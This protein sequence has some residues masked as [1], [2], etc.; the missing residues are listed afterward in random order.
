MSWEFKEPAHGRFFQE[1]MKWNPQW[2]ARMAD[3]AQ[4][5]IHHAEGDVLTHVEQVCLELTKLGEFQELTTEEQQILAW[6]ALLHDVAKPD[7]T[8]EEPSGRI[9][10][11][12]HAR[13]GAQTARRILWELDCPFLIREQICGLVHNHMKVFWA[14]ENEEPE[15]TVRAMSLRCS[16]RHLSILAEADARGRQCEDLNDLLHRV[17]LFR[18]LA[19]E[20]NCYEKP[21][22]FASEVGRYRYLQG[23]WHNPELP[24][25]EEFRCHAILLSGLPAS[26]KDTWVKEQ[27]RGWPVVSLDRWRERLGISPSG[28]QG[29]V[30]EA[31]REEAREY[32][33]EGRDFIWNA[34]NV[35]PLIR[36]KCLSLIE[37]YGA[38]AS[39]VYLEQPLRELARRNEKRVQQ[40]PWVAIDKMLQRWDIPQPAEAPALKYLI[41]GV[42][43]PW[44]LTSLDSGEGA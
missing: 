41:E 35:S 14:L 38:R 39:I 22:G 32:L 26:G 28:T 20:Y 43:V 36:R 19:Q 21:A 24:P 15:R 30:V 40:V 6:A 7:C 16:C 27:G 44:P 29:K 8:I 34:T 3:C 13:R 42:V 18:L 25:Y 11:P 1:A 37:E 9:R 12:G 5:P 23:K 10:S 2:L 31:A 33:R 17:E 4:D